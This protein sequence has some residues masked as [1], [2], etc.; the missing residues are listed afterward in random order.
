MKMSRGPIFTL[1][2]FETTKICLGYLP[3]KMDK[4][5]CEKAYFAPGKN[6]ER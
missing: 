4:F 3:T 1:S 2:L 6:Q 5:Y